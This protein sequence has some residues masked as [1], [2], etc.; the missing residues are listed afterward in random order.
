MEDGYKGVDLGFKFKYIGTEYTRVSISTHGY[1]CLGY[2][3]KCLEQTRPTPFDILI[4]LNCDLNPTR[5][6]SGQIYFKRLDSNSFDFR[7]AKIYLNLFNPEFEPQQIFMITYDNVLPVIWSASTSITS[8]QIYLSTDSV[9][10]FVAFKFKSCPKDLTLQSSSG[11]N[12]KQIDGKLQEVIITNG[13][14]CIGSNVGQTGVWVIDVTSKG[15][16][17][18]LFF[19]SIFSKNRF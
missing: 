5:A 14:Q 19:Y 3:S 11:L 12:Y 15:K 10:S 1:V 6:G 16:I 8:F 13:Q 4:G 9:K 7:T 18:A 2:N 17:K